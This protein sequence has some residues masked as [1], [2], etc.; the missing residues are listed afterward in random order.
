MFVDRRS[1]M[2]AL[3][4]SAAAGPLKAQA[5]RT[6][7]SSWPKGMSPVEIGKRVAEHFVP[8]PHGNADG[9]RTTG[10][11]IYPEGCAWYGALTFA[12]RSGDAGL[13]RRLADRFTPLFTTES[14][15]LPTAQHV[16]PSMFGAVPLELYIETRDRR[17]LAIGK[18]IAD[19]QWA[20]LTPERLSAVKPDERA[21]SAEAV[22]AG[23]SPQ[24]RFW[25]D[26]MYM[27]TILQTQAFRATGDPVYLDR[28][29]REAVAYLDRLQQPNGLFFHAPDVPFYWGRGNGW[30][31]VGMAELLRTLPA[32]DPNRPK[33]LAGY[34]KMMATLLANQDQTGMW[35]QLID[36]P[37]SWPE[38]S[39]TAMFTFAMITGAKA[40]W[41]GNEY[42]EAARKGW[43]ALCARI[44]GNAQ[45]HDVCEGT[46]K[47]NDYQ[48]YIDRARKV[49]DLHGQAPVLWCATALL[50]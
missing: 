15:L 39:G 23:L 20:P 6:T 46:N 32:G 29:G 2:V 19:R 30:F 31:A 40:G 18:A 5:S 49:G 45:L 27:I 1:L 47:K 4:A 41:L 36:R 8:M 22:A 43:L 21:I 3:A 24:T 33:I 25:V 11:I 17:Y 35:R 38:S 12:K 48:Y 26:D 13:S 9:A 14:D 44:D 7:L 34:R 42:A 16:D 50:S 37:E 10:S 28:A